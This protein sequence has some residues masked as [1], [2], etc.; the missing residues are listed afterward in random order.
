MLTCVGPCSCCQIR[1]AA[2]IGDDTMEILLER[3]PEAVELFDVQS[4]DDRRTP[5]H[6]ACYYKWCDF[7]DVGT[8]SAACALSVSRLSLRVR[9]CCQDEGYCMPVEVRCPAERQRQVRP[10]AGTNPSSAAS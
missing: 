6:D 1:L 7:G 2:C 4:D 3:C 9:F 5:L 10:N 8:Q